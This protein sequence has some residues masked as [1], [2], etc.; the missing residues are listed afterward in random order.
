MKV[1]WCDF[2][3]LSCPSCVDS[4]LKMVSYPWKVYEMHYWQLFLAKLLKIVLKTV[5][6]YLFINLAQE[7]NIIYIYWSLLFNVFTVAAEVYSRKIFF[8]YLLPISLFRLPEKVLV[9]RFAWFAA[10][11]RT[12]KQTWPIVRS[13]RKPVDLQEDCL[14]IKL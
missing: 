13:W 14:L 7:L 1:S 8:R 9:R 3:V 5:F 10:L 4:I 2:L 12:C 6:L 11:F